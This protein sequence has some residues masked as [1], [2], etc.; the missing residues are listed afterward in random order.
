MLKA[1]DC[2]FD[3]SLPLQGSAFVGFVEDDFRI[4]VIAIP[5]PKSEIRLRAETITD[6]F[7]RG[8]S[9][10]DIPRPRACARAYTGFKESRA[11]FFSLY[12]YSIGGLGGRSLFHF[13]FLALKVIVDNFVDNP[14]DNSAF[15]D[16]EEAVE[17]VFGGL[18][19][20]DILVP[21]ALREECRRAFDLPFG[22]FF[23]APRFQER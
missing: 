10:G 23:E 21:A 15:E 13:A 9:G 11:C 20:G 18:L 3:F 17:D 8:G 22:G 12:F 2:G 19:T 6:D 14:V 16:F 1:F 7:I 4:V 5:S